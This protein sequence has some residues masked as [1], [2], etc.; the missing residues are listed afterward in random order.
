MKLSG[1]PRNGW[2]WTLWSQVRDKSR[3]RMRVAESLPLGG[4]RSL[5]L[6]ECEGHAFLVGCG[7]DQ[8]NCVVPIPPAPTGDGRSMPG[9]WPVKEGPSK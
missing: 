3:K 4:R 5:V 9:P 2:V 8:V 7:H 6:V 1:N